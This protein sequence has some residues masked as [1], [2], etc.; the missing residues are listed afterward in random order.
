MEKDRSNK[1]IPMSDTQAAIGAG[2]I[3]CF[4]VIWALISGLG[5][6]FIYWI[7]GKGNLSGWVQALGSVAAIIAVWWQVNHQIKDSRKARENE[8]RSEQISVLERAISLVNGIRRLNSKNTLVMAAISGGST[9]A[10]ANKLISDLFQI[11][12]ER[13]ASMLF[14][15]LPDTTTAIAMQN[16]FES[17]SLLRLTIGQQASESYKMLENLDNACYEAQI[18][19]SERI[20]KL[21]GEFETQNVLFHQINK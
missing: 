12:A 18:L 5:D 6:E 1:I 13:F 14:W 7:G 11:Y 10:E 4:F 17:I 16:I 20:E 21:R 3:M 9:F 15:E 8:V 19:I 2:V